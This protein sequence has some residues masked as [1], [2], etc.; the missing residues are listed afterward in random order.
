MYACGWSIS[1]TNRACGRV[2]LWGR[3]NIFGGCMSVASRCV[4]CLVVVHV[5]SPP[6]RQIGRRPPSGCVGSNV[7]FEWVYA[8][9]ATFAP[10][11]Q[12]ERQRYVDVRG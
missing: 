2:H 8:K 6:F 3:I 5:L 10:G 11:Y 1:N 9:I 12:N 7:S 4:V